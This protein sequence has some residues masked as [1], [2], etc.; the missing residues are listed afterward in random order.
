MKSIA[1]VGAS[2]AGLRAVETL[3]SEGFDGDLHLVGDEVHRPYD[4]PPLS[5]QILSGA[6]D[7]ERIWLTAEETFDELRLT[8]HLGD[9][10]VSLDAG[11]LTV[12]L[13][14]GT[15][16]DVDGVVIAT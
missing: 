10:A 9:A 2:L 3:R 16:L 5:K 1:V 6:W 12:T 7:V 13:A 14:S 8:T 15:V 4:R 11:A